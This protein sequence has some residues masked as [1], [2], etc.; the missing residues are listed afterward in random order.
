MNA[1]ST[2]S[3]T[4]IFGG[5]MLFFLGL[6]LLLAGRF[7]LSL[8]LFMAVKGAP[9]M[10]GAVSAYCGLAVFL[11]SLVDRLDGGDGVDAYAHIGRWFWWLGLPALALAAWLVVIGVGFPGLA[12]GGRWVLASAAAAC[13]VLLVAYQGQPKVSRRAA[14]SP[15]GAGGSGR[16]KTGLALLLML[17]AG[18]LGIQRYN[19]YR[20]G[21]QHYAERDEA[22]RRAAPPWLHEFDSLPGGLSVDA[23]KTRTAAGGHRLTCFTRAELQPENR[24]QDDDTHN[25]WTNIGQAWGL[26]ARMAV[27]GFGD[28]GLRAQ[29][30]RFPDTAWPGVKAYLDRI[31]AR[32]EETFGIDPASQRPIIGWRIASGLIFSSVPLAGED[33]IVLWHAKDELARLY[34]RYESNPA[35]ARRMHGY[36]VQVSALWPE[37]DCRQLR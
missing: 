6:V 16:F 28:N 2:A 11:S 29:M 24:L 25:C 13:S 19:E 10:L 34:C 33:V 1:S 8:G 18:W 35:A 31:G 27:F 36:V 5:A 21:E 9:S 15:D 32:Q 30:L 23:L 7:S 20:D 14:K 12:V 17:V 22:E 26:P 4:R 37:I 3:R